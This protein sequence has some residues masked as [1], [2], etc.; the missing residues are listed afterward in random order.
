MTENKIHLSFLPQYKQDV[1]DFLNDN[2]LKKELLCEEEIMEIVIDVDMKDTLYIEEICKEITELIINIM[3]NKLLK[4]YILTCNLETE[5]F[6]SDAVYACSLE[7]FSKK[8]PFIKYTVQNRV[9]EYILNNNYLNIDGFVKF[10]MKELMKYISAIGDIALE[11]YLIKKDQDEFVSVL[12]YFIDIQ[13]EKID[14]LRI[15]IMNDNSF[16]LYDKDGNRIENTED[17][18]ILNMMLKED[19]NYE[20]FLISTLLALCPKKIEILD[21]MKNDSSS[22]IVDMIKSIFGDKVS[23]VLQN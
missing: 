18:E 22:E 7:I 23:I 20:D 16:V 17:E 9:Y 3:K 14:L 8:E 19:L 2:T 11:E 5:K 1:M 15:H 10:R 4:E 21:S 12:K 13:E 6:D